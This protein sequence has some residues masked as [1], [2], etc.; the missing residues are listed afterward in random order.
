MNYIISWFLALTLR[1]LVVGAMLPTPQAFGGS[2]KTASS[3]P[4]LVLQLA[5][6]SLSS[7]Q[8]PLNAK[9]V[10]GWR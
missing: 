2:L 7:S 3:G 4:P 8:Q 9:A 5:V 6:P 10:R 1:A